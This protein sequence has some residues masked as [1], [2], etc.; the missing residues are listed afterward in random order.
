MAGK[1]KGEHT[2]CVNSGGW[3]SSKRRDVHLDLLGPAEVSSCPEDV[4][5]S[6]FKLAAN[7]A[8]RK[9]LQDAI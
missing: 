2:Y 4:K 6:I 5:K 7:S 9:S 8:F 1:I 3:L